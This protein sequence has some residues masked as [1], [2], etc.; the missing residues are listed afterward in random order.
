MSELANLLAAINAGDMEQ[1][2]AVLAAN[3]DLI[4]QYDATG[5]TP[6]HYATLGGQRAIAQLLVAQGAA[7][8]CR[9]GE[10]GATPT[11]WAI[12]YLR[13]LGGFLV[14]ELNDFEYAIR[15][16]D[17]HW[18]TRFLQRWPALREARDR[19]G[20]PFR[21]HARETGRKEIEALLGE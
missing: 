8:N 11:G 16:G 14:T 6:L 2:A 15:Q 12:E 19:D 1:V 10:F 5:A 18:V 13:E 7:I 4:N 9:D 20:K 17:T 3:T 21:E